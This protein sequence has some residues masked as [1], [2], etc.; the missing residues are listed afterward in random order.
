MEMKMT[1]GEA[2]GLHRGLSELSKK[3]LPIDL[4]WDIQS[5]LVPAGDVLQ[6][7]QKMQGDLR[8]KYADKDETGKIIMQDKFNPKI[9]PE[10]TDKANEELREL[11]IKEID[12]DVTVI[13]YNALKKAIEATPEKT[14]TGELLGLLRPIISRDNA[15]SPKM[16][17]M[18]ENK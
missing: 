8:D 14:I 2:I 15:D 17:K 18:P 6:V 1:I 12:I 10:N 4:S 11:A 9:S 13:N 5:N 3:S 16:L 7:F